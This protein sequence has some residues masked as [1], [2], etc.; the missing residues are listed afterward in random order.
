MAASL[1]PRAGKSGRRIG[2]VI[3]SLLL[4]VGA[5]VSPAAACV[6]SQRSV[7]FVEFEEGSAVLPEP[8][9]ERFRAQLLGSISGQKYVASYGILASGD[10]AEGTPW[11]D[12]SES[13][14]AAD[15]RLG[16][17]RAAILRAM[18][19]R[20]PKPLR[21]KAIEVTVRGNRQVFTEAQLRADPR[22]NHRI[23]GAIVADV[24]T[25]SPRPRKGQPVPTC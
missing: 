16:Q 22:L 19:K 3:A 13:V 25:R 11:N 17:A 24:R 10:V 23:R 9:A 7:F 8:L 20:Q 6:S 1:I 21:S 14:R 18:L 5:H 4:G 12:A 2:L 15:L